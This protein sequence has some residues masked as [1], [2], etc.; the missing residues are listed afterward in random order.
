MMYSGGKS[1]LN[2]MM[3]F[4]QAATAQEQDPGVVLNEIIDF[5]I[6]FQSR[7]VN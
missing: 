4:E 1:I 6:L 5:T 7:K 2:K 3:G